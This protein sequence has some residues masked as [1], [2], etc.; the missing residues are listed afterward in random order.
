MAAC[1]PATQLGDSVPKL[2]VSAPAMAAK[3]VA[4]SGVWSMAGEA[5][6]ASSTFA[7]MF[8]AT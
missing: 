2:I 7:A 3:S 1:M 5:P 4:S 6:A 8:M